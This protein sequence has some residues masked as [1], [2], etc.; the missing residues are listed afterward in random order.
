MYE[1]LNLHEKAYLTFLINQR[2]VKI[3]GDKAECCIQ[4][5]NKSCSD[6]IIAN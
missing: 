6:I 4:K 2:L 3:T 1:L 5:S